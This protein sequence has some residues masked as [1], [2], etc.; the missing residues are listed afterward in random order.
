VAA[1]STGRW[2]RLWSELVGFLGFLHWSLELHCLGGLGQF[3]PPPIIRQ[4]GQQWRVLNGAATTSF[5]AVLE[6]EFHS[7]STCNDL[8]RDGAAPL[9]SSYVIASASGEHPPSFAFDLAAPLG[10]KYAWWTK[11]A[12]GCPARSQYIGQDYSLRGY[13]IQCVRV[14]Q[15]EEAG[16]FSTALDLERWNGATWAHVQSFQDVY[17][18]FFLN[19]PVQ[20]LTKWRILPLEVASQGWAV[21]E[22]SFYSDIECRS[23]VDGVPGAFGE[24]G[25]RLVPSDAANPPSR[26]FDG[27]QSGGWTA[28]CAENCQPLQPWLELNVQ[29]PGE[30]RCLRLLQSADAGAASVMVQSWDGSTFKN[31]TIFTDLNPGS[32]DY[33]ARW[34]VH[35]RSCGSLWRLLPE[36]VIYGRWVVFELEMHADVNC[37]SPVRATTAIA[38]GAYG[39]GHTTTANATI[40][41]DVATPWTSPKALSPSGVG[42]S[43]RSDGIASRSH[44]LGTPWVGISTAAGSIV[45][46]VRLLQSNLWD[47]STS[48]L[49]LQVWNSSAWVDYVDIDEYFGTVNM[50]FSGLTN[51]NT[52]RGPYSWVRL[53]A[54]DRVQW[55]VR[56]QDV[57]FEHWAVKELT[58]YEAIDCTL[59][60]SGEA[61]AG[62]EDPVVSEHPARNAFDHELSTECWSTCSTC[63]SK[64]AWIGIA[65]NKPRNVRCIKLFQ[66][67]KSPRGGVMAW[68]TQGVDLDKWNGHQWV[69]VNSYYS[70]SRG[71][72]DIMSLYSHFP[73]AGD[74]RSALAGWSTEANTVWRVAH[75][76]PVIR[77]W[78]VASLSFHLDL[79]CQ[80]RLAGVPIAS[81]EVIDFDM[82]EGLDDDVGTEWLS[83]CESCNPKVG[84]LGQVMSV[85]QVVRCVKLF[86]SRRPLAGSSGV[87]VERW[88]G[89]AW[90]QMFLA[91]GIQPSAWESLP[92]LQQPALYLPAE[93]R[94]RWRVVNEAAVR[95]TWRI[96]GLKF[97]TRS[98]CRD[99]AGGIQFD[100]GHTLGHGPDV[101][102]AGA[103]SALGEGAVAAYWESSCDGCDIGEAWL[104]LSL[105]VGMPLVRCVQLRQ[106]RDPAHGAGAVSVQV[107]VG[108]LWIVALRFDFANLNAWDHLHINALGPLIGGSAAEAIADRTLWRLVSAAPVDKT[109]AVRHLAFFAKA[110]PEGCEG[111]LVGAPVASGEADDHPASNALPGAPKEAEWRASCIECKV[112]AA[113]IGTLLTNPADVLCVEFGQSDEAMDATMAATLEVW[114]GSAWVVKNTFTGLSGGVQL[115]LSATWDSP[116]SLQQ[117]RVVNLGLVENHWQIMELQ[118]FAGIE[119]TM[120]IHGFPIS[121]SN[122]R[123]HMPVNAFDGNSSTFWEV[124]GVPPFP[125]GSAWLGAHYANPQDVKCAII[126]QSDENGSWTGVVALER[127]WN[128]TWERMA[129]L[130]NMKEGGWFAVNA[131]RS[132]ASN[133]FVNF[134]DASTITPL[135]YVADIGLPFSG[136][137]NNGTFL[138][139]GW[140]CELQGQN[141]NYLKDVVLDTLVPVTCPNGAWELKLLAGR[142]Y[143]RVTYS[144]PGYGVNTSGCLVEGTAMSVGN[145]G[146][147]ERATKEATINVADAL[148]TINASK[149]CTS[150]SAL[151][152]FALPS[153]ET[154]WRI[155]NAAPIQERWY[156]HEFE[157][158][159]TDACAQNVIAMRQTVVSSSGWKEGTKTINAVDGKLETVWASACD[160]CAAGEAWVAVAFD[161]LQVV[162]CLR[163]YQSIER[164]RQTK[165]VALERWNKAAWVVFQVFDDAVGG[166][167]GQYNSRWMNPPCGHRW[168]L[169]PANGS[170]GSALLRIAE[171]AFFADAA[172]TVALPGFAIASAAGPGSPSLYAFDGFLSTEWASLCGPCGEG[173]AWVGLHYDMPVDVLCA[174]AVLGE[175]GTGGGA[176]RRLDGSTPAGQMSLRLEGWNGLAWADFG[177]EIAARPGAWAFARRLADLGESLVSGQAWRI[178]NAAATTAPWKVQELQFFT[179][180]ECDGEVTGQAIA[181]SE[182]PFG[183]AYLAFDKSLSFVSSWTSGCPKAGCAAEAEW[184]GSLFDKPEAFQCIKIYQASRTMTGDPSS[185]AVRLERWGPE[186][187]WEIVMTFGTKTPL[188]SGRWEVL[189]ILSSEEKFATKAT[190]WRLVSEDAIKGY[191]AMAEVSFYDDVECQ[192][193]LPGTAEASG[194][195]NNRFVT[196]AFDGR[197]DTFWWSQDEPGRLEAW[198]GLAVGAPSFIRC[199]TIIQIDDKDHSSIALQLQS[200]PDADWLHVRS[201]GNV[202]VG[203]ITNL[204]VFE[205]VTDK[206]AGAMWRLMNY[207]NI[208]DA[209]VV[210]ELEFYSDKACTKIEVGQP[211]APGYR[212]GEDPAAAFDVRPST[213]WRSPCWPCSRGQAWLGQSFFSFSLGKGAEPRGVSVRCV[214]LLQGAGEANSSESRSTLAS[215][216]TLERWD[217]ETWRRAGL[218]NDVVGGEY[219]K[220]I[221]GGGGVSDTQ[222]VVDYERKAQLQEALNSVEDNPEERR[223][224]LVA[225][226]LDSVA[227]EAKMFVNAWP[228]ELTT[229][230]AAMEQFNAAFTEALRGSCADIFRQ[231]FDYTFAT[232]IVLKPA[233]PKAPAGSEVALAS[234]TA[235]VEI[236]VAADTSESGNGSAAPAHDSTAEVYAKFRDIIEDPYNTQALFLRD[237]VRVEMR[238]VTRLAPLLASVV[239]QVDGS[240]RFRVSMLKLVEAKPTTTLQPSV[241]PS[242]AAAVVEDPLWQYIL[243]LVAAATVA[244]LIIFGICKLYDNRRLKEEM[245]MWQV[246]HPG[247][248]FPRRRAWWRKMLCTRLCPCCLRWAVTVER[249]A[250]KD[251][252]AIANLVASREQALAI[253]AAVGGTLSRRR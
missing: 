224:S 252:K 195:S 21:T 241:A 94:P 185:I 128:G 123:S 122:H 70:L 102:F 131:F 212:I 164:D 204:Q 228:P 141:R 114:V 42:W 196:A 58:F 214:I 62:G 229:D 157:L 56:Q 211:L 232:D 156:I 247:V 118:F 129:V 109:W 13:D 220:L 162:N 149:S 79:D 201:F 251:Q 8:K 51:D 183:P 208:Y 154:M 22:L 108:G 169:V 242:V 80:Q 152:V 202:A 27:D 192:N 16:H 14:L 219:V 64:E 147:Y 174:A 199:I 85:P 110:G 148:L 101:A 84:W 151:E 188:R 98:A 75:T 105:E 77:R 1:V 96:A 168:R 40:D 163:L 193:A 116:L 139:Y 89:S 225:L 119:C 206:P 120:E 222:V 218:F 248:P 173:E 244:I 49:V 113:W 47:E 28:P 233:D 106:L 213:Q 24:V 235:Q 83:S 205:A 100:S 73:A 209:W 243:I 30:M 45:R 53:P 95:S 200:R 234:I 41:L 74:A 239:Q 237:A 48:S 245:D 236:F 135:G 63:A 150:I 4:D 221:L 158:H 54:V 55:R 240:I 60:V 253:Q 5:W 46:C 38:A 216:A 226:G 66:T 82:K 43:G 140:N 231:P 23:L 31:E 210:A 124:G 165:V 25:N 72:W 88:D 138:E 187:R 167:W 17:G 34:E 57:L 217:G 175:G 223:Q 159:A 153:P 145:V 215:A 181:S 90:Q 103:S 86:Q 36:E 180:T 134:Q 186:Q 132:A 246:A 115:M 111:L 203:P 176:A 39:S 32:W 76:V 249:G 146:A 9:A 112:G 50:Q 26:A 81:G 179:E 184:V 126:R 142:Y 3:I 155:R 37:S 61:L 178:V 107:L 19:L 190:E 59:E 133:V 127:M 125:P 161:S 144:D 177:V 191:W 87:S 117:F 238:R 69:Q 160:D 170:L 99:E 197:A 68:W 52:R 10:L 18:G 78:A 33:L 198:L 104:G 6:V 12:S 15:V 20:P 182:G 7:A 143:V 65:P 189:Q 11:C 250:S 44:Q 67:S 171:T 166:L 230:L 2:G 92:L 121:S 35:A 227:A 91:E 97:F 207:E 137:R 71:A 194:E 136:K 130:E 172:C 29:V 93:S